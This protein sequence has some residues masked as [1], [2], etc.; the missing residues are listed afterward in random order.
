MYKKMFAAL[1]AAALTVSAA[2]AAYAEYDYGY[3]YDQGYDQ[4]YGYDYNTYDNGYGYDY[5]TGDYGEGEVTTTAP[6]EYTEPAET[7]GN[8]VT[9]LIDKSSSAVDK[10]T[11]QP[12]RVYLQPG[13]F[14][15][16]D[17]VP[18]ELRIEADTAVY[19]ALISVSFDTAVLELVNTEL[20][21]EAGGK[22]AENNF[23]G[24]YIFN[25]TND[26]GSKFKGKYSTLN[27][28]LLDKEM[29]STTVFLSVT[30]L[31]ARTGTPISYSTE[32]GIIQNPNA[33]ADKL[34][35]TEQPKLN[36]QVNILLSKGQVTTEELGI[37]DFR[38][39][40]S[41]DPT[42][43]NFEDGV[44][45]VVGVGKTTF[46]VVFNNNE[47]E[48]YDV[49]VMEDPKPSDAETASAAVD[50]QKT[51]NVDNSGRNL[52]ILICVIVAVVIIAVEYIIIM[53]PGSSRKRR[54]A[55]VEAFFENEGPEDEDDGE[56]KADLQKAFAAR[57]ARRKAAMTSDDSS[58][59]D[60]DETADD[61]ETADDA[62]ISEDNGNADEKSDDTED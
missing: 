3:G 40:V 9:S 60:N 49:E 33:P 50:T 11:S 16:D 43:V 47:L 13:T 22:A 25:Y 23:N 41:A 17:T 54:L 38:N 31:D 57:D 42:V 28:K 37:S 39:I 19:D 2:P 10:P 62:A 53:K 44:L 30:T 55:E 18:V 12:S 26:A 52:F 14:G 5:G 61:N 15:A 46:D 29:V 7:A 8:A 21:A 48:T 59:D 20:N 32:N 1:L 24:K 36:K 45:K 58:A 35:Q 6:V 4:G 51:E 27:F 34:I 56:M